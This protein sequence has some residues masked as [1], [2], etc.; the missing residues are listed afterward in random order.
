VLQQADC[1]VIA[2]AHSDYDWQWIVGNSQLVIDTRN[3]TRDVTTNSTR[4]VKL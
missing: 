4:V 3:A 1:V 2:A